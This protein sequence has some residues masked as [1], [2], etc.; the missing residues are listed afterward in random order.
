M[1]RIP[2]AADGEVEVALRGRRLPARV[3]RLPF[4]RNGK[5]RDG[6]PLS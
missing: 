5:P 1:A 3:T 4:V 6:L 2:A